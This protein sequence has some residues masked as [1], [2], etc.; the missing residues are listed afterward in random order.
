[1]PSKALEQWL[2]SHRRGAYGQLLMDNKIDLDVLPTLT[3]AD[4]K[5]LGIA[6]GDRK[7]VLAAIATL[8]EGEPSTLAN[9]PAP[10]TEGERRQL[11][12][13]FCDM[14][15]L[16]EL[17]NRVDP[18]VLQGIVRVYEDTCAVCV[19]RYEGYVFQR[20]G[21]GIVAFFGYPLAHEGEAERALYAALA[22]VDAIAKL[23]VQKIGRLRVRIGVATVLVVVASVEKGAVGETVNLAARLQGVAPEV[24]HRH[25]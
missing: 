13:L 20:L 18:E 21:D 8:S 9:T 11:T 1:M 4:F 14:V 17:A 25:Q 19:S 22:T 24:R 7:R 23:D 12:V 15:E 5:G 3:E 10:I 16:T 6:L 2:N